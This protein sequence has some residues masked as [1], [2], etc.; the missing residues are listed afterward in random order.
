MVEYLD[1][2]VAKVSPDI[3]PIISGSD[4][5]LDSLERAMLEFIR[6]GAINHVLG[7]APYGFEYFTRAVTLLEGLLCKF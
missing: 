5:F 2:L 1:M 6:H 3:T 7:V 4:A